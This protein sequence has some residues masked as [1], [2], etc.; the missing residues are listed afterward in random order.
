MQRLCQ[1]LN[2]IFTNF[3][4]MITMMMMMMIKDESRRRT[5][6]FGDGDAHPLTIDVGRVAAR[7]SL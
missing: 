4:L 1:D 2:R 7:L 5:K 6:S 3:L